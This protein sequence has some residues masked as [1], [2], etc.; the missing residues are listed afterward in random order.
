MSVKNVSIVKF[1]YNKSMKITKITTKRYKAPLK[2][3][4]ITAL[5]KVYL[6]EDL[7]VQIEC[8]D[9]TI[10]YGEGVP[11]PAITGETF[12]S[13]QNAIKLIF[14]NIKGMDISDFDD[15]IQI[16]HS[17]IAKNT[18][19]KS[20]IEIALYDIKAKAQNQTLHQYLGATSSTL[21]T[22]I[23][24]SL[25]EI[26]QM[27]QDSLEAIEL[28]Y[29]HLKIK[30]GDNINK[31][32]DRVVQIHQATKSNDISLR[33]DAN[34]GWSS[35]ECIRLLQRL[36]RQNIP[37]EFIEQP[38]YAKDYLGLKDIKQKVQTPILADES[39]YDIYDAK[40][41]LE[42]DAIDYINIKLD[43]CG[44]ISKALEIA[45]LAKEYDTKCMIGCM[46]EGPISIS[47]AATVAAARADII[48]MID[49]DAV[50]L[51][52][53]SHQTINSIRFDESKIE[54]L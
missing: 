1:C 20:A 29:K 47:A 18:T 46:L 54:L 34:Q 27:V 4:F 3:P 17:S 13:M 44:G 51:L 53:N 45:N 22:D 19:A 41:L 23:T 39:I 50:S 6:L 42:L 49:L 38:V 2:K 36:E 31:D 32:I 52:K 43:K 48:T 21:L 9:G 25:N 8:D 40:L 12:A 24:I 37:I 30:I 28:G 10:G 11:T 26:D 16:L 33:L 5:R 35:D 7:I 15:I 14:E